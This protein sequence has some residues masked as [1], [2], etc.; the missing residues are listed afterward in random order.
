MHPDN[1]PAWVGP[2]QFSP[3]G[4]KWAAVRCPHDFDEL[5]RRTGGLWEAGSRRWLVERRR[6]NPLI[7]TLRCETDPLFPRV[8]M[9]LDEEGP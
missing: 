6:L 4:A 8:G 5:M 3:F 1:L 2:V 9:S 7:R